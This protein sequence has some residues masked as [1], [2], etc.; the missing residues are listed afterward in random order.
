MTLSAKAALYDAAMS[1]DLETVARLIKL[2]PEALSAFEFAGGSLMKNVPFQLA[3]EADLQNRYR[4][5]E[6]LLELG[7]IAEPPPHSCSYC[8]E[9]PVPYSAT[10]NPPCRAHE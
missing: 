6:R 3:Q 8:H 4:L 1:G 5:L 2:H 9:L 10:P 7:T